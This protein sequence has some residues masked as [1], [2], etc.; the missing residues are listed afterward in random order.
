MEFLKWF[1]VLELHLLLSQ[2]I[3]LPRGIF[4]AVINEEFYSPAL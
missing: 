1:L 3:K 2:A 4:G